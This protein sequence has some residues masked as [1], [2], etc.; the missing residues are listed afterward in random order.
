MEKTYVSEMNLVVRDSS[1]ALMTE[2]IVRNHNL[3]KKNLVEGMEKRGYRFLRSASEL[4]VASSGPPQKL[5][6]IMVPM[7]GTTT[8]S[9]TVRSRVSP[10]DSRT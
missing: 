9:P 8:T 1:G 2:V 10:S 3:D 7:A 4:M 6:A 5:L